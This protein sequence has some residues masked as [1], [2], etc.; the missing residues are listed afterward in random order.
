MKT[1]VLAALFTLAFSIN[2]LAQ[3]CKEY[4]VPNGVFAFCPPEDWTAK[5]GQGDKGF[6]FKSPEVKGE[7]GG[8]LLVTEDRVDV[9]RETLA[10]GLIKAQFASDGFENVRLMSAR[11]FDSATGVKGTRLV[12]LSEIKGVRLVQIYVIFDGPKSVHATITLI[13]GETDTKLGPAVEAMLKSV[14][15]KMNRSARE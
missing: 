5:K 14:R 3:K 1:L 2:G 11:D 6:E 9:D 4:S 13:A 12:F 8:T 10:F 7:F 15:I